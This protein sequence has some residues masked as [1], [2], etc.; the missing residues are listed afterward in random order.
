M[1][2]KTVVRNAAANKD[3]NYETRKSCRLVI[4]NT[5]KIAYAEQSAYSGRS[6]METMRWQF[7]WIYMRAVYLTQVNGSLE[8]ET[9]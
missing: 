8:H 6:V 3:R 2:I 7:P 5:C 9:I 1:F 4:Q